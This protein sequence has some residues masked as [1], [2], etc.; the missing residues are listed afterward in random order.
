MHAVKWYHVSMRHK[1]LVTCPQ[2]I[3]RKRGVGFKRQPMSLTRRVQKAADDEGGGEWTVFF[4]NDVEF[5][6]QAR[7]ISP[8][9]P[10]EKDLHGGHRG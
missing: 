6:D 2:A 4:V 7:Q 9:I 10:D 3:D 8:D 1:R 5:L